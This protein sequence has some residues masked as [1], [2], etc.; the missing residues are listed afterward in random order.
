VTSDSDIPTRIAT[1]L[2]VYT[3]RDCDGLDPSTHIITDLG[4][5]SMDLIQISLTI[6]NEFGI[7]IPDDRVMELATIGGLTEYIA[8]HVPVTIQEAT[9]GGSDLT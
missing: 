4:L 8:S 9:D 3:C 1:I 6:E 5:D 2:T 7:T